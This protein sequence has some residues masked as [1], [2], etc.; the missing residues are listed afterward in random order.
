MKIKKLKALKLLKL[1]I[2]L[3]LK[4]YQY[5]KLNYI[6]SYYLQKKVNINILEKINKMNFNKASNKSSLSIL[7]LKNK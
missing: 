1:V 2:N 4:Y 3:K 5:K 7:N 6:K